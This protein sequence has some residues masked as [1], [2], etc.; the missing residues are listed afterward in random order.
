MQ[1]RKYEMTEA[2]W[3]TL[4]ETMPEGTIAIELGFLDENLAQMYS[5]DIIWPD[6]EAK[7]FSKYKVWPEPMGY[8]SFGYNID[9][10]YINAYNNR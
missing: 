5:I 4:K 1:F 7:N 8:H 3:S 10:D 2:T 9:L 6:T